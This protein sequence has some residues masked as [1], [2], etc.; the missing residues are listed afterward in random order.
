MT[1]GSD[2]LEQ[3]FETLVA[4]NG[5]WQS[6]I[7]DDLLWD[8]VYA[9]SLGHPAR[10]SGREEVMRHVTWFLA[11]VENFR[12]LD[13]RIYPM[14]DPEAAA[15]EIRAEALIT[16]TGRTY[17]QGMWY[18]CAARPAD[19]APSRYFDPCARQGLMR[20]FTP[21]LNPDFKPKIPGTRRPPLPRRNDSH[22]PKAFSTPEMVANLMDFTT[23]GAW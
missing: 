2:L 7:D 8:L 11:A 15:A 16:T 4:D 23:N 22:I 18:S 12:F 19:Y 9:P 17:R 1:I 21:G 20:D 5:R 3:H 14:A 13:L 10:L 6:L